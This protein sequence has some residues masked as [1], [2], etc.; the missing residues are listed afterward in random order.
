[1]PASHG[2]PSSL[3]W[4]KARRC[5]DWNGTIEGFWARSPA[6]TRTQLWQSG[7]S[8]ATARQLHAQTPRC[9]QGRVEE[10][11]VTVIPAPLL[12]SMTRPVPQRTQSSESKNTSLA[13]VGQRSR[14][15]L[16]VWPDRA[17]RATS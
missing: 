8:G 11:S 3:S 17:G 10:T 15:T 13:H 2:T 14:F 7:A 6:S 16:A 4:Y 12:R 1:M 5:A 9:M